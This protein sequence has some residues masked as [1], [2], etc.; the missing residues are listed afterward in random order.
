MTRPGLRLRAVASRCC[1][2]LTMERV[3]DPLLAD[4]QMEH[5]LAR[6]RGQLWKG[7][8]IRLVAVVALLKAIT[9]CGGRSL[10]SSGEGTKDEHRGMIR[11]L[12]FSTVAMGV[13]T[14]LL[15][16]PFWRTFQGAAPP[17]HL[18][19]LLYL[20]PQ[21]LSLAIPIGLTVGILSGFRGRALSVRSTRAVLTMAL[22]ASA[23]A[24]ALLV[25]VT[26]VANQAWRE[27]MASG[28]GIAPGSLAKGLNEMS[29]N[30]LSSQIQ[31][32][33][34]AG[35]EASPSVRSL[36]FAYHQRWSLACATAFL[37]V[38]AIG[39]LAFR[40]ASRWAAGAAAL[41]A[42]FAY[43]VLLDLGR[44]AALGGAAPAFAGAWLPNI[45]FA[46]LSALL[47]TMAHRRRDG[48]P[49]PSEGPPRP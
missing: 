9:L 19:T 18:G 34:R 46:L 27:E 14:V 20:I 22:I 26:P 44:S 25:W 1:G 7:R 38:Y 40:C 47:L 5:A 28:H 37:A 36:S 8:W 33:R 6:G 13:V 21:A 3:V 4:L 15:V 45:V 17:P 11:T 42:C 10:L 35:R 49:V 2:A 39:V 31:A 30:D 24:F 29:L 43:Y 12:T 16:G 48:A 23:A 41:G 32:Y